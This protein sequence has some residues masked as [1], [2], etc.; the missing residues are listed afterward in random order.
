[1]QSSISSK[2]LGKC[3]ENA[4]LSRKGIGVGSA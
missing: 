1:M 2:W 4:F 3:R